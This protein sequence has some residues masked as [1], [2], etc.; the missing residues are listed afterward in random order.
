M[1]SRPNSRPL[2]PRLALP[3]LALA[4]LAL[5]RL[6]LLLLVAG[7]PALPGVLGAAP[8]P[9]DPV[10]IDDYWRQVATARD[11]VTAALQVDGPAR[12]AHLAAA[13]AALEGIDAVVLP[14]GAV[15]PVDN[16]ALV[17]ELRGERPDVAA[18]ANRLSALRAAADAPVFAR[19]FEPAEA[20]LAEILARSEFQYQPRS[21]LEESFWDLVVRVLR[22]AGTVIG[23]DIFQAGVIALAALV[24]A[25]VLVYVLRSA[26][27]QGL[28]ARGRRDELEPAGAALSSMAA[29]ERAQ[30]L[31]AAGDRR[32]AVRYLYLST[33]LFLEEAG[34]L[35]YDRTLTNREVLRQVA[36]EPDVALPLRAVVATFERVWYGLAPLDVAGYEAFA[37]QVRALHQVRIA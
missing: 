27:L 28:V 3:R 24:V 31:A 34:R 25:G 1:L 30:A 23:S 16:R 12:G 5:A 20:A 33:L 13:A 7:L 19:A 32:S 14:G 11:E 37:E 35:R 9:G 8:R 22:A 21:P 15:V 17:A 29:L 2:L 36:A 26:A 6:A 4:R 10:P 18:L